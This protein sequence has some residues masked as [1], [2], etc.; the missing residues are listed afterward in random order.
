MKNRNDNLKRVIVDFK[1]L[2]PDLSVSIN[3]SVMQLKEIE[4][5]SKVK[6]ILADLNFPA[7]KLH[8]EVT[9]S[10]FANDKHTF[11]YVVKSLQ[12]SGVRISLDDFGTGYSSITYL[13]KLPV[14]TL[15]IDKC[16]FDDLSLDSNR[17]LIKM[18]I[19]MAKTFNM[20]TISEGIENEDQLEFIKEC[21]SDQYQGFYFSKPLNVEDFN[22]YMK[23]DV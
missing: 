3:V 5:A 23:G 16:F 1:K 22:S 12:E 2:T 7:H 13:Q 6:S 8:L 9:E 21:G 14:N 18:V 11:L 17:E 19:N 4:F 20:K 15:K 10:V